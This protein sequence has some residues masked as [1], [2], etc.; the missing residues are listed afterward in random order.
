MKYLV[1]L[2]VISI[3]WNVVQHF[4]PPILYPHFQNGDCLRPELSPPFEVDKYDDIVFHSMSGHWEV[5]CINVESE[6]GVI[7]PN[8]YDK[9]CWTRE[10]AGKEPQP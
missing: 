4:E 7:Q 6:I 3:G 9:K 10:V 2:L 5:R 1:A 8:Y